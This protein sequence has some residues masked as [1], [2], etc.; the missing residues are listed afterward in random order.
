MKKKS[1]GVIGV[2]AFGAFM[3]HHLAPFFTLHL[4]DPNRNLVDL[5]RQLSAEAATLPQAAACPIVVL[6]VP[7]QSLADVI[8]QIIPHLQSHTLVLDV[9]SVKSEPTALLEKLLPKNIEIIGTHPL[10]GPQSGKNGIEGLNIAVCPIRTQKTDMVCQFLKS[11]LKL[12]VFEISPE[13]HDRQ[14]AYVQGLTH[15]IAKVVVSL[16]LPNFQLTTKTFDYMLKMVEMVRYDSD[17]LFRAIEKGNPFS[18]EAKNA[19]FAAARA[20]E[21]KLSRK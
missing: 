19:F 13:E 21:E 17:E 14:M 6:A 18:G 9:L 11:D 2:G 12:N 10:F 20:L 7:V 16:D 15:L 8:R 5:A 4:H 3:A 1:L